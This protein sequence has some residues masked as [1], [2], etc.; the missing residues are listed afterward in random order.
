MKKKRK[1]GGNVCKLV[2]KDGKPVWH[3]FKYAPTSLRGPRWKFLRSV[4]PMK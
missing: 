2:I 4:S 1:P 3:V